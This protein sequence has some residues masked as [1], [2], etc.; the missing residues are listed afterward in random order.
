MEKNVLAEGSFCNRYEISV[1]R[2]FL[3]EQVTDVALFMGEGWSI[4]KCTL[5][6]NYLEHFLAE[7]R[8]N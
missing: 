4:E 3:M 7:I 2:A 8:Q 5:K 6:A 1:Q